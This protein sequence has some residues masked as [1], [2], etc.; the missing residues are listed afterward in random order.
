MAYHQDRIGSTKEMQDTG[1]KAWGCERWVGVAEAHRPE[2]L[3]TQAKIPRHPEGL[4]VA[5]LVTVQRGR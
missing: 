4:E 3:S 5:L 2:M 1:G